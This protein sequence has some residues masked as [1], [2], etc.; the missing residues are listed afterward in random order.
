MKDASRDADIEAGDASLAAAAE[1]AG[2]RMPREPKRAA[3]PNKHHNMSGWQTPL[4]PV[5]KTG[6]RTGILE[7]PH[8]ALSTSWAFFV[9]FPWTLPQGCLYVQYR[10]QPT[11][12]QCEGGQLSAGL[13][14]LF[15]PVRRGAP[16]LRKPDSRF[17]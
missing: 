2:H 15:A 5:A 9:A 10:C 16:A 4:L 13:L 11:A 6:H 12:L 8:L 1:L 17:R 3:H 14:A 7:L